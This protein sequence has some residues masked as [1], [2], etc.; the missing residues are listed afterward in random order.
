MKVSVALKASLKL[1]RGC[2]IAHP[3]FLKDIV[4]VAGRMLSAIKEGWN[5]ST[6]LITTTGREDE[7]L[8][9]SVDQAVE[10]IVME[11]SQKSR[12]RT[13]VGVHPGAGVVPDTPQ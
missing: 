3:T 1:E 10:L 5:R 6:M 7:Y 4:E 12:M 9:M 11:L 13:E 8:S 2:T